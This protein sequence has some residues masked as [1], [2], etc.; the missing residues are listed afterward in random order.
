VLNPSDTGA[1]CALRHYIADGSGFS[2]ARNAN[3]LKSKL[4]RTTFSSRSH[5]AK[6]CHESDKRKVSH[7]F[8]IGTGL[9]LLFAVPHQ[10]GFNIVQE[11]IQRSLKLFSRFAH[12]VAG[13]SAQEY[14]GDCACP[15]GT[16]RGS[17]LLARGLP[18]EILRSP[19]P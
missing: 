4:K 5:P 13:G 15:P 9:W 6:N 11:M 10:S 1:D 18:N 8:T 16:H 7:L 12:C 17:S 14:A 19:L 2:G 3:L